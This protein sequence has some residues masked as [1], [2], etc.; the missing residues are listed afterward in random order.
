MRLR[1]D[2]PDVRLSPSSLSFT[3]GDD[4]NWDTPQTVTARA[5]HDA[6]RDDEKATVSLS[7]IGVTPGSLPVAL[8]DDDIGATPE[9]ENK[10]AEL[11]LAAIAANLAPAA[12]ATVSLRFDAPRA[13]RSATVAGRRIALDRSLARSLAAGFAQ[14]AGV[15]DGALRGPLRRRPLRRRA[16]QQ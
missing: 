4:G 3:A 10:G 8:T 13:G 2:N 15:R 12:S 1:S 5:A 14:Q 11:Q 7:G 9:E 16:P 6:D